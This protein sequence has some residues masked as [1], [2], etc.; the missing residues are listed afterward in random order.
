MWLPLLTNI[1]IVYRVYGI[2]APFIYIVYRVYGYWIAATSTQLIYIV[3]RVYGI[4]AGGYQYS[5]KMFVFEKVRARNFARAWGF[6]QASQGN[7]ALF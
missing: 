5:L 7:T 6:L 2:L 1:Y 3:H 4:S